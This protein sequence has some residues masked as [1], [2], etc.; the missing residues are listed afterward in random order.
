MPNRK[1]KM[2]KRTKML[3]RKE[4]AEYKSKKREGNIGYG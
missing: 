2:R 1:A 4:I 3:K